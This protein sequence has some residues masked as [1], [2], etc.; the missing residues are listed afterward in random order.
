LKA[1]IL[2][3]GGEKLRQKRATEKLEREAKKL[4]R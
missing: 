1:L 4:K 3:K 2:K